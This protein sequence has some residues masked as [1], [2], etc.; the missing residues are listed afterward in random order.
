MPIRTKP[1]LTWREFKSEFDAYLPKRNPCDEL[2]FSDYIFRGQMDADFELV[3]SFDRIVP[4]TTTDRTAE[5]RR[6]LGFFRYLRRHIG[7]PIDH[8]GQDETMSLAQHYGVSTRLLDW[9][10]S[11][12]VAAFFAFF[13]SL[14]LRRDDDGDVAICA[15]HLAGFRK[16][17]AG[18]FEVIETRGQDNVRARNQLGRFIVNR[19]KYRSL[20]QYISEASP[21]TA[22]TLVKFTVPGSERIKA[23][24]DLL[25]MGISPVEIYPDHEGIAMYVR[26]R[27]ALDGYQL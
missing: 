5:F 13:D 6:W 12:Y 26:L 1:F 4:S 24:N 11:P 9:T 17:A 20:D 10:Y 21:E 16:A 8:L 2:R 27:Q 18:Q 7:S 22:E 15:I 23:L 25:L 19:S 14:R 3:S